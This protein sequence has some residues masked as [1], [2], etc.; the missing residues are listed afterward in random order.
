MCTKVMGDLKPGVGV[1]AT[2]QEELSKLGG[3]VPG[4]P[5]QRVSL[6]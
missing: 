4:A 2:R 5:G 3:D 6:R 1:V